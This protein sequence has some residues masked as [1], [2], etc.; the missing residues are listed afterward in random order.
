MPYKTVCK[1]IPIMWDPLAL[2]IAWA[3]NWQSPHTH[4]HTHTHIYIYIYVC[5]LNMLYMASCSYYRWWLSCDSKNIFSRLSKWPINIENKHLNTKRWSTLAKN[6]KLSK[7]QGN[8]S[9][10]VFS[11]TSKIAQRREQ[12]VFALLINNWSQF[13]YH[14]FPN[15]IPCRQKFLSWTE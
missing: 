7:R 4:T 14:F 12:C 3:R 1:G 6:E 9:N 13:F 8:L 5:K 11:I 15:S 2:M 10:T